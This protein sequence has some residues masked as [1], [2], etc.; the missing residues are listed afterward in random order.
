VLSA[1]P[2]AK[3]KETRSV[4]TCTGCSDATPV[5]S[6]ASHTPMPTR[7]RASNGTKT[8]WYVYPLISGR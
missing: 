8:L 1:T 2:S 5:Q 4:P 7:Q 6:Q 3:V